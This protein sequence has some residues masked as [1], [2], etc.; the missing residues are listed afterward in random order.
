MV[1]DRLTLALVIATLIAVVL[2]STL[3]IS[4]NFVSLSLTS[5]VSVQG[6]DSCVGTGETRVYEDIP[7]GTVPLVRVMATTL[8]QAK[9]DIAFLTRGLGGDAGA[10]A[11]TSFPDLYRPEEVGQTSR[12]D[13]NIYLSLYDFNNDG[14]TDCAIVNLPVTIRYAEWTNVDTLSQC[15]RDEW[16]FYRLGLLVEHERG[17]YNDVRIVWTNAHIKFAGQPIIKDRVQSIIKNLNDQYALK[18]NALDANTP[19]LNDCCQPGVNFDNQTRQCVCTAS[20]ATYNEQGGTADNPNGGCQCPSD[21]DLY[22]GRICIPKCTGGQIHTGLNGECRCPTFTVWRDGQC[23]RPIFEPVEPVPFCGFGGFLR[24][25]SPGLT[26]C[27]SQCVDTSSDRNNCGACGTQCNQNQQCI[28]GECKILD[29]CKAC[30]TY[31]DC[32]AGTACIFSKCFPAYPM[33]SGPLM[34]GCSSPPYNDGCYRSSSGVPQ[35][36]SV[37]VKSE[38]TGINGTACMPDC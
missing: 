2:V 22:L 29:Q 7:G 24:L 12:Y 23:Q 37:C 20:G 15:V 1:L 4:T 11:I 9:F 28:N 35:G 19:K 27:G 33:V 14:I 5:L 8:A 6:T 17:H 10:G 30:N 36:S 38:R 3:V 21:Q 32:P 16:N 26:Q 34:Y 31:R 25:F 13:N 18:S